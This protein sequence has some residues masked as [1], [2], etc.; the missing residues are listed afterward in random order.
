MKQLQQNLNWR[1]QVMGIWVFIVLF[2][3]CVCLK[4]FIIKHLKSTFL[5]RTWN[6]FRNESEEINHIQGFF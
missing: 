6:N 2:Y 3:F 4:V 5:T 1:I